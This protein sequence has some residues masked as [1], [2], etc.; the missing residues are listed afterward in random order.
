MP[1]TRA[2]QVPKGLSAKA[3]AL[4]RETV[5]QFEL[6][7]HELPILEAACRELTLIGRLE[8]EI[9]ELKSLTV[10][11]SMGQ[12]VVSELVKEVRQHRAEFV[13]QVRALQLPDEDSGSAAKRSVSARTAAQARWRMA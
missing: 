12:P 6:G 5:R 8:K 3:Q 10:A 7:A 13:R 9:G 4:W 11:G 2:P 1:S